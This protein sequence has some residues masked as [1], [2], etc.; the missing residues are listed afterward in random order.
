VIRAYLGTA[1]D[2]PEGGRRMST[3]I[4]MVINGWRSG[5][6]YALMALGFT[7]IFRAAGP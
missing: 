4:Q 6:V 2:E 1:H 3:F 5:S 7:I